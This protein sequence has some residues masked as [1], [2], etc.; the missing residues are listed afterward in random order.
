[1]SAARPTRTRREGRGPTHRLDLLVVGEQLGLAL[2]LLGLL[3]GHVLL[4]PVGELRVEVLELGQLGLQV[5]H[6]GP[7]LLDV[8]PERLVLLLA[9]LQDLA[10]AKGTKRRQP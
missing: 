1:M 2:G 9:L 8:V 4:E 7:E 10:C 3:D 5:G 6:L